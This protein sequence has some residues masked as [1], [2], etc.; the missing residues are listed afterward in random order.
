MTPTDTSTLTW[1]DILS[2]EKS[3]PYFIKIMDALA[4]ERHKGKT[5]FPPQEDIFNALK[6]T[7][8]DEIKVVIIG[9]DPYH[10]PG[11]AHGLSFSVQPGVTKPP[12]LQNI[13]KE[14][15]A[16]LNVPIPPQGCLTAWAKQG[17]LLLN[18]SLTVEAHQPQSHAQI[19]WHTFTDAII[20]SLNQHPKPIAFLLWGA[21]AQR[22]ASLIHN[23]Q[24]LILKAAHP[25]PL[26][27]HRG[28]LGCSHFSKTNTF[29][30]DNGR[31][32]IDWQL[33][34]S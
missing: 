12:S 16:D 23:P 10:G 18:A 1:T 11:Q 8:F 19:G 5:I 3:K 13:F 33:S 9:Q 14:L 25:S 20:T 22:K 29:L 30:N 6:W 34:S 32:P 28:F 26:S 2:P 21:S 27:A 31:Q 17:V 7:P 4:E 24:H 15:Q